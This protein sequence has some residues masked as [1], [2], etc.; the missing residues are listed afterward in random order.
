MAL[1]RHKL[2]ESLGGNPGKQ[3]V[4]VLLSEVLESG[5]KELKERYEILEHG[6]FYGSLG[7]RLIEI[8]AFI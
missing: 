2:V 6:L 3:L 4:R 1:L 5:W 7:Y 8:I